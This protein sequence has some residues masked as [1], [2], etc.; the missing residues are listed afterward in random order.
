[1]TSEQKIKKHL[2][3]GGSAFYNVWTWTR[4]S[5]HCDSP[6]CCEDHYVSLEE[7]MDDIKILAPIS[8]V[9]LLP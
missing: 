2:E 7:A 5:R 9:E 1:M 3:N 8:D 4:F 6:G